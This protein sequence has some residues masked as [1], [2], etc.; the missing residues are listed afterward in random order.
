MEFGFSEEMGE[1]DLTLEEVLDGFFIV[2]V[3]I[4]TAGAD[5]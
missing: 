3:R 2:A 5:L 1:K 4:Q